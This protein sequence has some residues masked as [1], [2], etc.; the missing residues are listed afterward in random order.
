MIQSKVA[1]KLLANQIPAACC[2]LVKEALR[3]RQV[4]N[5]I[6]YLNNNVSGYEGDVSL[7]L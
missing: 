5:T 4:Q 2:I 3:C 1:A 7:D 6:I